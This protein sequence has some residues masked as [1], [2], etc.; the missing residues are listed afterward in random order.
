MKKCCNKNCAEI[1]PQSPN[2]FYIDNSRKDKLQ[3]RCKACHKAYC[4][5]PKNLIRHRSVDKKYRDSTQGQQAQRRRHI[6]QYWPG[7][8][9]Y[10]ASVYYNEMFTAQNGC[11]AICKS[12]QSNYTKSL[13]ID[14]CHKTGVVRGLLCAKCNSDLATVEDEGFLRLAT[15]YLN[16]SKIRLVEDAEEPAQSS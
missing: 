4:S 5:K 7:S 15:I 3:P 12:H 16:R 1:N 9:T 11:C 2:S 14:H 13:H 6:Q 10:E 8:T